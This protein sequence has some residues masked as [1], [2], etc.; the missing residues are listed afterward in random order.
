VG[1]N[2]L[3][4]FLVHISR[5]LTAD[6]DLVTPNQSLFEALKHA[7]PLSIQTLLEKAFFSTKN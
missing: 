7:H 1:W 4:V 6:E 5:F 3:L 2:G